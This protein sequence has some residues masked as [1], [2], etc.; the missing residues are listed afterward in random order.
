METKKNV[1]KQL[2]EAREQLDV[3][4]GRGKEVE[5]VRKELREAIS[6][7]NDSLKHLRENEIPTDTVTREVVL[8]LSKQEDGCEWWTP[9]L[10]KEYTESA[11]VVLVHILLGGLHWVHVSALRNCQWSPFDSGDCPVVYPTACDTWAVGRVMTPPTNGGVSPNAVD[12]IT[13]SGAKV[14]CDPSEV[15]PLVSAK[16][17]TENISTDSGGGGERPSKKAGFGARL[18]RRMGH[19]EGTPLGAVDRPDELGKAIVEPIEAR[20]VPKRTGLDFVSEKLEEMREKKDRKKRKK[21][22]EPEGGARLNL[23]HMPK[24]SSSTSGA[25]GDVRSR[26]V[27]QLLNRGGLFEGAMKL[28]DDVEKGQAKQQRTEEDELSAL[29]RKS[30]NK[31]E[32][33]RE[34]VALET[35][36]E[37]AREALM[38]AEMQKT[39]H[40][41]GPLCETYE[42]TVATARENV[43]GLQRRHTIITRKLQG[44]VQGGKAHKGKGIF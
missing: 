12:I 11:D 33:R 44:K 40:G 9:C 31:N 28:E 15:Y 16:E 17:V 8:C 35:E 32:M 43:S 21:E 14:K 37:S 34:L 38:T 19:I 25:S 39:R 4:E 23:P 3:L 26:G 20:V 24:T 2:N 6:L 29:S 27:F 13:A 42:A 7:L 10:I 22:W 18:L 41:T 36:I 5:D 1:E 30:T